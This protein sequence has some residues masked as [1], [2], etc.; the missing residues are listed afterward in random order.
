MKQPTLNQDPNDHPIRYL[1]E[2]LKESSLW[3]GAVMA[4]A[5]LVHI[6]F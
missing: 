3:A 1:V 6:L 2:S 4:V 5:T